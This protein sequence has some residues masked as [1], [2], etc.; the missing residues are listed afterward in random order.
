MRVLISSSPGIGHLYPTVPTAWALRAA[1]HD[2]LVATGGNHELGAHAGLPVVDVAPGTDMAQVFRG[3]FAEHGAQAGEV[4]P[5]NPAA[6]LDFV[7]RLFATVSRHFTEHTVEVARR[8][9]PD[10]VL[11]TPLQG[12]G[13]LAAQVVGVPSVAHTIGVN[14]PPVLWQGVARH[15]ADEYERFGV[16]YA[17]PVAVLDVSPPSLR[18]P[19]AT[20]WPMRYVP[21]NGGAVLPPWVLAPGER[22]LVT[23]TLGSVVP[24][25]AGGGVLRPFVAAAGAAPADFVITLGGAD[26]ADFGPLPDNVRL[27]EWIPLSAVLAVSAAAIHH[28]GAG[29]TL[30]ALAAGLPQ[31]VLPQGADQF[32]N[33]AGLAKS[34][35]GAIVEPGDLDADRIAELLADGPMRAAAGGIAAELAE[36]PTPADLVPRLIAL[37]R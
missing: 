5:E 8:W 12:A 1:G 27:V 10:L 31:L 13:Q 23:V 2:V 6:A 30:T 35:A 36:Q 4:R 25:M 29:S 11:F 24:R 34:G 16:R 20:G 9:R 26:P 32:L 7:G 14:Q 18:D 37:A 28:G 17:D 3:F 33:A 19:S 22:P 21:Y 15:L